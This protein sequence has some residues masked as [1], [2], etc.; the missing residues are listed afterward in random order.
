M[1]KQSC[2][3]FVHDEQQWTISTTA[4]T[5]TLLRHT[6]HTS[7]QPRTKVRHTINPNQNPQ[8]I[9]QSLPI[10]VQVP[11]SNQYHLGTEKVDRWVDGVKSR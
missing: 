6:R 10:S 8:I 9:I 4:C 3:S 11:V 7:T 5:T 2:L 1:D